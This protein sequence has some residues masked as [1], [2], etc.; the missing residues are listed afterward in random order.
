MPHPPQIPLTPQTNELNFPRWDKDAPPGHSGNQYPKML[1]RLFTK[2]DREV[3]LQRNERVDVNSRQRYY[4]ERVPK[5]GDPV[6][7]VATQDL[8]DAGL[9]R[10]VGEDVI[11]DDAGHEK[12]VWQKL[13]LEPPSDKPKILSVPIADESSLV[14]ENARLRKLLKAREEE[15]DDRPPVKRKVKRRR[16]K[17]RAPARIHAQPHASE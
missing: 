1:T 14:A 7:V 13:G 4:E 8:V 11:V 6:P 12:L 16:A 9:A 5:L 10:R 2:E 17:R 3:W 15:D